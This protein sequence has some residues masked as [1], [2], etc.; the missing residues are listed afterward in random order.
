[1]AVHALGKLV[2]TTATAFAAATRKTADFVAC[3]MD[4]AQMRVA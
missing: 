2:V 3:A 1:M 4:G